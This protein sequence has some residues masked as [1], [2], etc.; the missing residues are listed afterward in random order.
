MTAV[1]K[2][3]SVSKEQSKVIIVIRILEYVSLSH[4]RRD[5]KAHDCISPVLAALV[6]I[7]LRTVAGLLTI[8]IG[9]L[10]GLLGTLIDV[11]IGLRFLVL[12][13]VLLIVI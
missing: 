12:A 10:V 6:S 11:I 8:V 3:H 1:N 5:A 13:R 4:P 9:L 7:V 2:A